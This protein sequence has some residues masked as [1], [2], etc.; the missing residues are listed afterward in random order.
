MRPQSN[1]SLM[2]LFF[3]S[4]GIGFGLSAIFLGLMV[5]FNFLNVGHLLLHVEGGA[6]MAFVFW[7]IAATLFGSV[8][9]GFVVMSMAED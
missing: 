8:Q 3:V 1:P 2:R 6:L 5:W 7:V 4:W 9:F